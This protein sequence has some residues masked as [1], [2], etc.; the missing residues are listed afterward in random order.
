[1]VCSDV[2]VSVLVDIGVVVV[3]WHG[4]VLRPGEMM[5]GGMLTG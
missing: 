1:M 5:M 2:D 4:L 3:G